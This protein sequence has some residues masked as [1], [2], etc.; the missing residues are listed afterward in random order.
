MGLVVV[1]VIGE[2][3]HVAQG[4]ARAKAG[5]E[6]ILRL[7]QQRPSGEADVKTARARDYPVGSAESEHAQHE[8]DP[9]Q[10]R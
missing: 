9:Y 3:I 8:A 7:G 4:F 10:E 5:P 2:K 6:D 1:I